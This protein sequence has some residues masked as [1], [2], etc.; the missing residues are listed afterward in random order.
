MDTWEALDSCIH[1]SSS[2]LKNRHTYRDLTKDPYISS[3]T[4]CRQTTEL[5]HIFNINKFVKL[6]NS[7]SK[8][9]QYLSHSQ[10]M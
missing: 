8:N 7:H 5:I 9:R 1:P 3:R 6:D 4:L 2:R 10:N